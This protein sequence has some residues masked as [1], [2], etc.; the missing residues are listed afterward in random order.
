[1]NEGFRA[2][3]ELIDFVIATIEFYYYTTVRIF[4]AELNFCV[5]PVSISF[6][7]RRYFENVV[8]SITVPTGNRW[9]SVVYVDYAN[10]QRNSSPGAKKGTPGPYC[11]PS[12]PKKAMH[13]A[14]VPLA[15]VTWQRALVPGHKPAPQAL[16]AVPL[17]TTASETEIR[18]KRMGGLRFKK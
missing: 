16:A 11:L 2:L 10:E 8:L 17:K 15:V 7:T 13:Q 5:G 1:V 4:L 14:Y 3:L 6:E 9:Y 12:P 18:I